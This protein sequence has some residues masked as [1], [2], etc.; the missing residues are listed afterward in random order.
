MDLSFLWGRELCGP[1]PYHTE[2][3]LTPDTHIPAYMNKQRTREGMKR[4]YARRTSTREQGMQV[5]V[6]LSL[7]PAQPCREAEGRPSRWVQIT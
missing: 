5:D 6:E 3:R 7:S 4:E 1:E 2:D